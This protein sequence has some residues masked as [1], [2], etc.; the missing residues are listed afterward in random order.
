MLRYEDELIVTD[1]DVPLDVE[2]AKM[3]DMMK[4]HGT[5]LFCTVGASGF[6]A[7]AIQSPGEA[8]TPLL[9]GF[10]AR[11]LVDVTTLD[12]SGLENLSETGHDWPE[13]LGKPSIIGLIKVASLKDPEHRLHYLKMVEPFGIWVIVVVAGSL[14]VYEVLS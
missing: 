12:A 5:V 10:T 3:H 11:T 9:P 6:V 1:A 2:W 13:G 8:P 14:H 7:V 4:R